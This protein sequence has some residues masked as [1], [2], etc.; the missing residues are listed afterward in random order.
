[1]GPLRQRPATQGCDPDRCGRRISLPEQIWTGWSAH[2]FPE[3]PA[4]DEFEARVQKDF[5][6]IYKGFLK[7]HYVKKP[8][9]AAVEGYCYAGGMEILQA[10]DVRVA[11]G[12]M[13]HSRFV[14]SRYHWSR[15]W[16]RPRLKH[17]HGSRS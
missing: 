2:S 12:A 10:F 14:I 7:D 8:I 9:V 3:K 6:I 4:T 16:R 17:S 1:M 13:V 11:A 15:T 5:S